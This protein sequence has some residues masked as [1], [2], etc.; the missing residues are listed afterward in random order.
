M[1]IKRI[2]RRTLAFDASPSL[3]QRQSEQPALFCLPFM[4]V[5]ILGCGY[6]GTP[7]ALRLREAGHAVWA[8]RRP[9]TDV[10]DLVPH[11]II[12]VS[13]EVTQ[14]DSLANGL[15]GLRF[16]WM[17]NALS[18]RGGGEEGYRRLYLQGTQNI[19]EQFNKNPP[20]CYVHLSSTS[21]YGQCDGDWVTE[22]S[23]AEP[24]N[25]T[26]RILVEVEQALLTAKQ[27]TGWPATILRS[28]G[29]YGPDRGHL[30]LQFLKG[31]ARI[32]GDGSR[33][34]NMA[35]R[36]DLVAAIESSF[37]HPKP[38]DIVNVGDDEP[39]TEMAF[40]QWLADT[41]SRPMPPS[42]PAEA[43][44]RKRGATNKQVSNHLLKETLLPQLKYP[45]YQ[46]GYRAEI[47]R[48]G[49]QA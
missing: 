4:R 17:V 14:L 45:S 32:T 15:Q 21:V 6:V 2:G 19:L 49:L 37:A 36:D 29:I 11:G 10:S 47:Q 20:L 41:L 18:S 34:L 33:W 31:E 9:G 22:S 16:D 13:A 25:G 38:P 1:K 30:F 44:V 24:S 39:V 46:S 23:P 48:L 8:V 5:L 26:S 28:A 35:H 42:I 40:F 27:R 12:P 3:S 43:K 7:L